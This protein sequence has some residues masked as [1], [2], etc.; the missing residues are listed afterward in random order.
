MPSPTFTKVLSTV[1][2]FIDKAK[3]E[4]IIKRQIATCAATPESFSA[5]E[6]KKTAK[7]IAGASALYVQDA[8]RRQELI[9]KVEAL[10]V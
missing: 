9:S 1:S 10:A 2:A 8:A 3:A 7:L 4:D 5:A 6:L